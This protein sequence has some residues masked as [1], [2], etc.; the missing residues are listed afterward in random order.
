M[1]GRGV[2]ARRRCGEDQLERGQRT[3]LRLQ[4]LPAIATSGDQ[5]EGPAPG[6]ALPVAETVKLALL[7]FTLPREVKKVCSAR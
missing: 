5:G 3:Q 7:L 1:R 4:R 2:H 6:F